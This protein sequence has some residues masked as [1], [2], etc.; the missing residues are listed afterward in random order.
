MNTVNP[1]PV[2]PR[3][4]TSQIRVRY[5][6]TDAQGHVHH[7]NFV[8]YF[9]IGRVEMLRHGGI[10][11]REFEEMGLMLVVVNLQCEYIKPA[12]YD[13]LL[14]LKTTVAK[15]R[16]VRI[17]HHYVISSNDEILATGE[18]TVA[19]VNRNGKPTPLP[20]WLRLD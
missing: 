13:D 16:G 2:V 17:N 5:Q 7:G 10:S 15:A 12:K 1:S 20:K 9:E 6:E 8:N 18:T 19:C 14:T 11:Y 3:E 4:H